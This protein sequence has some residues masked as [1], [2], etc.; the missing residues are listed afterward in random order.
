MKVIF[1]DRMHYVKLKIMQP[2]V[3]VQQ[4]LK[5]IHRPNKDAYVF[6]RHVFQRAD[7][8]MDICALETFA[9]CRAQIQFHV[10]LV[11]DVTIAFVP[12][13]AIQITTVCRAKSAMNVEHVNR[14][15]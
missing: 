5:E 15:V 11:N 13:F 7:A 2:N 12:R 9:K 10:R 8:R 1:A 4:V 6:H 14:V 3:N